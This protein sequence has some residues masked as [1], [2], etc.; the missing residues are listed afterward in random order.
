MAA[1]AQ[2]STLQQVFWVLALLSSGFFVGT[3]LLALVGFGDAHVH[4]DLGA[5]LDTH[6][7]GHVEGEA[8]TGEVFE[9]LSLRNLLAFTLGF[10]WTGV[11]FY[12]QFG[13]LTLLLG[14]P[15]GVGFAVLNQRLTNSMHGLETSGNANLNEAIG[16]S[17]QVSVLIDGGLQ[18]KGKVVVRVRQRELELLAATEDAVSLRRGERVQ[19]Y[20]VENGVLLVSREDR[21]GLEK[22]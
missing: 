5:H 6:F 11:L 17:A 8:H 3:T 18:G 14:I 4:T 2:L 22:L 10:S 15:V 7:D 21:L 16:Q 9:Y 19:V 1:W 12:P 20:G 13:S